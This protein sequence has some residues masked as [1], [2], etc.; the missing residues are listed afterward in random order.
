MSIA[1]KVIKQERIAANMSQ[2]DLAQKANI[3]MSLLSRFENGKTERPSMD[4]MFSILQALQ[5]HP[6]EFTKRCIE[7]QRKSAAI[8]DTNFSI[9]WGHCIWGAPLIIPV[10][11]SSTKGEILKG[12]NLTSYGKYNEADELEPYFYRQNNTGEQVWRGPSFANCFDT[13]R[14]TTS[15]DTKTWP[16]TNLLK[17]YTADD[18]AEL[19]RMKKVDG[20]II[21]NIVADEYIE[22]FSDLLRCASIMF[23]GEACTF[24]ALWKNEPSETNPF[25]NTP[26]PVQQFEAF[27]QFLKEKNDLILTV[28]FA[29]GTVAE[30]QLEDHLSH[31]TDAVRKHNPK[32]RIRPQEIDLG[33]WNRG[34]NSF[35]SFFASVFEKQNVV[36]FLGWDPHVTWAI[37]EIK[38]GYVNT[39]DPPGN[40]GANHPVGDENIH[41]YEEEL[42]QLLAHLNPSFKSQIKHQIRF[43]FLIR[44]SALKKEP[45]PSKDRFRVIENFLAAVSNAANSIDRA[46]NQYGRIV[47]YVANYLD[48]PPDRCL[49]TLKS[50]DFEVWYHPDWYDFVKRSK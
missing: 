38:G 28:F 35:K 31:L 44:Q 19:Y 25:I 5:L 26:A 46:R 1:G 29:R 33:N 21:P 49:D 41:F 18:I 17:T 20:M 24:L 32:A 2:K 27:H 16:H 39:F 45:S 12:I 50:L 40:Q 47:Q 3:D 22:N 13:D 14:A 30:I 43:D 15:I 8:G 7:L 37:K 34:D 42:R 11:E 48:M 23:T 9:G 10:Y 36:S 4:A 6:Q